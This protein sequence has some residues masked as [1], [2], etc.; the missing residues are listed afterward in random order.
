MKC[1][2]PCDNEAIGEFK[3]IEAPLHG[4]FAIGLKFNYCEECAEED[5]KMGFKI[6]QTHR[7][8]KEP[9]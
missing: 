9:Q 7:K 6:R 4:E 3:I 8:E 1:D 5:R 2:G